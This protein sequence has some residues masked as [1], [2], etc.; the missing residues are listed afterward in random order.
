M[1]K[2]RAP[3]HVFGTPDQLFI[4]ALRRLDGSPSE[5]ERADM[6]RKAIAAIEEFHDEAASSVAWRELAQRT[7]IPPPSRK[8]ALDNALAAARRI[9]DPAKRAWAL[10]ELAGPSGRETLGLHPL[11][12]LASLIDVLDIVLTTDEAVK[13]RLKDDTIEGIRD[14]VPI[15]SEEV[16]EALRGVELTRHTRLEKTLKSTVYNLLDA[17]KS[18]TYNEA[19]KEAALG[20]IDEISKTDV[21]TPLPDKPARVWPGRPRG[22]PQPGSE[23]TLFEF[24]RETYGPY[25]QEHRHELRGFIHRNDLPLYKAIV[26]Y[27]RGGGGRELPDNISMPSQRDIVK[28]RFEKAVRGGYDAL[29]KPERRSVLGRIK[30]KDLQPPKP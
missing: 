11:D 16:S 26:A 3:R 24:I 20:L 17:S 23:E 19:Y 30:R 1:K 15:V 4:A 6:F 18:G 28:A 25:F 5:A 13:L 9:S 27:E 12:I 2:G 29:T 21:V 8:D 10:W 14:L 22:R 7:D